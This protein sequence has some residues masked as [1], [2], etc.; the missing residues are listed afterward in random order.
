M[1]KLKVGD[2]VRITD[3]PYAFGIKNGGYDT[4][5]RSVAG[6]LLTV[7]QIG[8]AVMERNGQYMS[9]SH[10]ATADLLVTDDKGGFWFT[11][12][13]LTKRISHTVTFDGGEV[14]EISDE[15]FEALKWTFSKS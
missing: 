11:T 6:E 12:S 7:V 5:C 8:L 2:K 3:W 13:Y 1:L 9:N 4:H 15:S 14:I 10:L